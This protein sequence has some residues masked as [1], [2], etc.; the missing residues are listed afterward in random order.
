M[1]NTTL[2]PHSKLRKLKHAEIPRVSLD[3]I[4]DVPRLP[5][6]VVLDHIRSLHNVG[7]IFR[8]SDAM[9]MAHLYLTGITATPEEQPEIQKTALGAQD[10]VPWSYAADAVS[11]VQQLKAEGYTIAA[12]ELTNHPSNFSDLK[13]THFPLCFIVGHEVHGVQ[14]DLMA[15]CDLALE[16]P[17][18]G[19]KQ[20]LNVSVAFGIAAYAISNQYRKENNLIF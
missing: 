18:Y 9:L 14:D 1:Q 10:T 7:A 16:I 13:A 15:L 3:Q 17:Q 2:S 12:L 4:E 8:T 11:L 6:V 19:I 5:I 20:S